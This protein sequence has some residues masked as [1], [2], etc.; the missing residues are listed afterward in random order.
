MQVRSGNR[1]SAVSVFAAVSH[2]HTP[3]VVNILKTSQKMQKHHQI[4]L[5]AVCSTALSGCIY[6]EDLKKAKSVL[7]KQVTDILQSQ[8]LNEN[9]SLSLPVEKSAVLAVL[10][11]LFEP[12]REP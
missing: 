6:L 10:K 9:T 7:I 1:V 3:D 12:L 5:K 4:H 8:K 2:K 11:L